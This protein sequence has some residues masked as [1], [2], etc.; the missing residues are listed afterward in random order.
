MRFRHLALTTLGAVMLTGTALGVG[1]ALGSGSS[2]AQ[3]GP[4]PSAKDVGASVPT[5]SSGGIKPKSQA[6]VHFAP[7]GTIIGP[8]KKVVTVVR[9][10]AGFYCVQLANSL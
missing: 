9:E 4:Q 3:G 2:H 5:R 7:D 1:V 10:Y 6:Y 8:P